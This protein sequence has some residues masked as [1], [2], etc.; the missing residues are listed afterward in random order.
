M[1]PPG[2]EVDGPYVVVGY[3]RTLGMMLGGIYGR[4]MA[5]AT[6]NG[7]SCDG[8][9]YQIAIEGGLARARYCL[10]ASIQRVQA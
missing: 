7:R 1:R 9:F 5:Q 4:A 6:I 3:G 10:G 8:C 2:D